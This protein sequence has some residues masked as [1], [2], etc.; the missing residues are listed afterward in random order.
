MTTT[1]ITF[2]A[3]VDTALNTYPNSTTPY[4]SYQTV[5]GGAYTDQA[6]SLVRFQGFGAGPTRARYIGPGTTTGDQD[7]TLDIRIKPYNSGGILL[8]CDPSTDTA[9]L[10]SI[11]PP[12]V[13]LYRIVAGV[14][15]LLQSWNEGL[16]TSGI[17][18][19]TIR[20]RA[21][22]SGAT[23]ALEAQ[24][25]GGAVRTYSDTDAARLTSGY[26]GLQGVTDESFTT[27]ANFIVNDLAAAGPTISAP[28]PSGTIG[29]ATNA[30]LGCTTN[31][32]TA[33]SN[34]LYA[35]RATTNI[36]SG[37]T[38]A[39]VKDGQNASGNTTGVTSSS[40]AVSTTT[41]S[42]AQ[43]SLTSSTTYY[44]ALV[45]ENSTGLSHVLT[46]S[47]TT[48]VSTRSTA[49]SFRDSAN[50]AVVSTSISWFLTSTWGGAALES[51]TTSTNG[52]GALLLAGLSSAAGSYKL[53]YKMTSDENLNGMRPVTL[54]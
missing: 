10:L 50:A 36:F 41:P 43:S 39:Q 5:G 8:R 13:R 18:T 17:V 12:N 15:T 49:L 42:V 31:A 44:Y 35:V 16:V 21:T 20:G 19:H 37:V 32:G 27:I 30:T 6:M 3:V 54:V 28:S 22:G 51:G 2:N 1:T 29:T 46:G 38:A 7:V 11:E 40:A 52:S 48:A 53:W 33:G 9:Y 47:F 4:F 26:P 24:I 45:Q 34:T 14:D 25:N 23:I